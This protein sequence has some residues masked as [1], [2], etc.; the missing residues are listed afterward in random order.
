MDFDSML[1]TFTHEL[2][3]M[4]YGPRALL[5]MDLSMASPPSLMR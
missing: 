2:V 4:I 1:E 3:E 5:G